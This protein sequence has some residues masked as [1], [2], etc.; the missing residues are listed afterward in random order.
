MRGTALLLGALHHPHP[1]ASP[2][3]RR[4][5]DFLEA[6]LTIAA[7]PLA[8]AAMDLFAVVRGLSSGA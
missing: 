3:A 4:A 7:V 2:V 1:T 5:V 6:G 8:L